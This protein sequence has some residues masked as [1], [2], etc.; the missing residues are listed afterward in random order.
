MYDLPRPFSDRLNHSVAGGYP[1][2][3]EWHEEDGSLRVYLRE[4][5]ATKWRK[6]Y[7]EMADDERIEL[8]VGTAPDYSPLR[9]LPLSGISQAQEMARRIQ[10]RGYHCTVALIPAPKS[11]PEDEE[12]VD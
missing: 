9:L 7:P 11:G 4:S 1:V 10:E 6:F 2:D 5:L 8:F 12:G 3:L